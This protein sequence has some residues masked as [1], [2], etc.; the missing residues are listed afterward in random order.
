MANS[1]P[2]TNDILASILDVLKQIDTRLQHQHKQLHSLAALVNTD[3]KSAG[4][5]GVDG[6]TFNFSTSATLV[7]V[8]AEGCEES[9]KFNRLDD[10]NSVCKADEQSDCRPGALVKAISHLP[11]VSYTERYGPHNVEKG[12]DFMGQ[13][14]DLDY[15]LGA[16]GISANIQQTLGDWWTIPDDSRV[17]LTFSREAYH[18][19]YEQLSSPFMEPPTVFYSSERMTEALQ[20]DQKLRSVSGNDF[21]VVDFDETN[22]TRLYRLGQKA[23]GP[24]LSIA[25][26]DRQL[27]PWSRLLVFQGATTGD[28]AESLAR[29]PK[30]GYGS[31]VPFSYFAKG[32]SD[33]SLWS[34]MSSHLQSKTL[35]TSSNPYLDD[36]AGFHTTFYEI[37]KIKKKH[38]ELW[39][40][41]PLY[42]DPL[43][44]SFRKCAF[45]VYS[46]V[47]K[48]D[49]TYY[50]SFPS[51]HSAHHWTIVIL[52]PNLFFDENNTCFPTKALSEG[53]KQ[54]LGHTL[55]KLSKIGAEMNIIAH[56]LERISDRWQ[57]FQAFFEY[58][59]D[60]KNAFMK[61]A[62]HDNLL[63]DDASF[64]RSRRYFWA[65][66]C[67][68]EFI[69]CITDNIHQ[70]ELFKEARIERLL[71]I[72][73]LRELDLQMLRNVEKQYKIL[74]NQRKYFE[75]KFASTVSLRDALFNASAV[76]ESRASTRLGENVKLLTFVSIFF[77]PLSFCASLWSVNDMF[78]TKAFLVTIILV[79]FSTYFLVLNINTLVRTTSSVYE[80]QKQPIIKAMKGD[81]A[82]H[83]KTRAKRFELFRPR[84]KRV[85]PSE[86]LVLLY[87]ARKPWVIFGLS[88]EELKVDWGWLWRKLLR[89]RKERNEKNEIEEI[90]NL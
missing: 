78:S 65:I 5:N 18:K 86:W 56:G 54:T 84:Y 71:R 69:T 66:N 43:D 10:S 9:A 40:N 68:S 4:S 29:Y 15:Y 23:I 12:I 77:L 36:T 21:L 67:L 55:G 34:H 37:I 82:E 44:R 28:T 27:S 2:G 57:D 22:N 16:V 89:R 63:F 49:R 13:S 8:P 52:C 74:I 7:S 41:G 39:K 45:T 32:N 70:W 19:I 47:P 35:N 59:L 83:W 64:S 73:A 88:T 72:D 46:R 6:T 81:K 85:R 38:S 24:P 76:I 80:R 51:Q 62:E 50:R 33:S 11:K 87:L 30:S 42:E 58:I 20:F 60:D 25:P 79:G 53:T 26:V 3:Y 61:P 1:T 14:V 31:S 17:R 75:Q 90:W 48:E